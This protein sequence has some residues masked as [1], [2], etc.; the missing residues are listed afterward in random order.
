MLPSTQKNVVE[1]THANF[2]ADD[3]IEEN[4]LADDAKIELALTTM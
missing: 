4:M 1:A 2:R 3:V